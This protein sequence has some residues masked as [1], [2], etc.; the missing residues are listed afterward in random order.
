MKHWSDIARRWWGEFP[1]YLYALVCSAVVFYLWSRFSIP[2][3]NVGSFESLGIIFTGAVMWFFV[4]IIWRLFRDRPARPLRW[5]RDRY[6]TISG[7]LRAIAAVPVLAMCAILIPVFSSLKAMIPLFNEFEWDATFIAWERTLLFGYDAWQI[8]QPLF[9]YPIVTA[10]IAVVY[11]IWI[12][13]LYIGV[14]VI[15]LSPG[16]SDDIRRRFFLSYALSWSIVGGLMATIFASVGPVFVEPILGITDFAAQMDY[17]RWA[18]EQVPVMT[19]PVQEGLL[20]G[21]FARENGLGRGI[22][23]MPSMHLAVCALFWLAARDSSKA[24]GRAFFWF[25]VVIWIGSVHTA[26][27]YALDG[28]V[29]LAAMWAIWKAV[30]YVFRAW[31]RLPVPFAQPTLRTNTVPAE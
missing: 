21:Y 2:Y 9:G 28:V 13:L 5:A 20:E 25:M 1:V 12:L 23:A 7:V 19:V 27:H 3:D 29:S 17:L 30:P 22:S 6:F 18:N 26:Y 16:V 10:A 8:L 14:A 24:W 11:H 15:A 31:D 4:D